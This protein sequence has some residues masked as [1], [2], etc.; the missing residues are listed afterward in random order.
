MRN[1]LL[2][3]LSIF[4]TSSWACSC[5]G[6]PTFCESVDSSWVEPDVIVLATKI[7]DIHYGMQV[8][9][10]QVFAGNVEV[11]DTLMV[12]GDNG[13]L[14]RWYTSG[15]PIGDTSVYAF[16]GTDFT[17]NWIIN[18]AYPPNLEQPGDYHLSICG[19]YVLNYTNG[20]VTGPIDQ[21]VNS[22]NINNFTTL[23]DN[24]YTPIV[25]SI[26]NDLELDGSIYTYDGSIVIDLNVI[27]TESP[28]LT[29][30]NAQGQ[31]IE[32]RRLPYQRSLIKL[33]NNSTGVVVVDIRTSTARLTK[34][35]FLN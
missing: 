21:N 8:K 9:V 13:I 4:A 16:H 11:N 29:V 10:V 27:L 18:P 22:M 7:S 2:L 12:W 30:Y 17:G 33:Q 23:V 5:F 14:C 15:W 24:C 34:R 6:Q 3:S 19:I 35:I 28:V 31:L 32:T 1:I 20:A 26:D 25:Q